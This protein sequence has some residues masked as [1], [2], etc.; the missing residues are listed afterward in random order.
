MFFDGKAFAATIDVDLIAAV[1][2]L[3][4]QGLRPPGLALLSL[5]GYPE[6]DRLVCLK[7]KRAT[8][9]GIEATLFDIDVIT[10]C[11]QDPAF[12][13]I[14][15]Q[16]PVPKEDEALI[17]HI[18]PEKDVDGL[19]PYHQARLVA[20]E[21][22]FFAPPTPMGCLWLLRLHHPRP[23]Q[24]ERVLVIG[25]S[26]LVGR[27]MAELLTNAD[28]TV[29][30]AHSHTRGLADLAGD[31][32]IIISATGQEDIIPAQAIKPGATVLDVGMFVGKEGKLR[33]DMPQGADAYAGLITPVPG[34]IGPL[35]ITGLM[36]NAV[37][38]AYQQQNVPF[39]PALQKWEAHIP[40]K[41][42]ASLP[43]MQQ[44]P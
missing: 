1:E 29:T 3:G 18:A 20:G 4:A 16:L 30:L 33:G 12:H 19:L 27:P 11:N 25:R 7:H 23:L 22:P 42:L 41:R 44:K 6:N 17:H 40:A 31:F 13:G 39:H 28:A 35:T 8:M 21:A 14:L 43:P 34:G 15:L 36:F 38:A 32:D 5:G 10:A 37:K 9:L 26:A 24:G 2:A